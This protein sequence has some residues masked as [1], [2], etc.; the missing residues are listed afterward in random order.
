[1]HK[2]ILVFSALLT[3]S[4]SYIVDYGP[5]VKASKGGIW[6]HPKNIVSTTYFRTL[7][8]STFEFETIGYKCDILQAA[9]DRYKQIIIV[10]LRRLRY[11]ADSSYNNKW[12]NISE[13]N[14][15]IDGLQVDLKKSC[16]K[17][18][19]LDMD[20]SYDLNI[21]ENQAMLS[22]ESI[23]GILR[24]LE[25]F[26]QLLY[27]SPDGRT[28]LVNQTTIFDEPRFKH[29]GLLVDTSRHFISMSTLERILDGMA[30]NKLNV[31]HW[32]IVDDHSFPYQSIKY[33]EMTRGAYHSSMIYSQKDVADIIEY[34]RLRGIRVMSE[35]DTPG[36]TAS[37][38]ASHPE[39]LTKCYGPYTGKLGPINP[40]LDE[41]YD[42]IYSLFDEIVDVFPDKYIHLG[43][44]EVGFECWQ[45][46]QGILNYMKEYNITSFVQLEEFYIQKLIDKVATLNAIPIVWQ[47]VFTNGVRLPKGTIVHV[48]TGDRRK[49]LLKITEQKLPALLS[50]CWYLDH[51]STGGDW[52]K[53][54]NCEPLDFTVKEDLRKYVL[55]GEACMWSE[56]VDDSNIVQR[57]FPRASA[58]AEKL[59]SPMNVV[60]IEDAKSRMEEHYCRMRMRNINA[61]PASGPGLCLA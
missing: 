9:I 26:S 2:F 16:E 23:W 17:Y 3:L 43:G 58:T 13:F 52:V 15:N 7:R 44:D 39:L 51:L 4:S 6:P 20:E 10:H 59:W 14:G 21:S 27:L 19:H 45:T 33:P 30:Y 24:G 37:W 32:H 28:L 61:Q 56:V 18:P 29:R 49:L 46:N 53:F 35:F 8:P 12:R 38:G 41:N 54:Y 34:A 40:I 31:F 5:V 42:F 47:E 11:K 36:H 48:W 1:M 55:G 25:S 57:I 60:D 50:S 22:A